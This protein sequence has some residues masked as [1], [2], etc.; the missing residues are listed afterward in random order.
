MPHVYVCVCVHVRV[1]VSV[2]ARVYACLSLCVSVCPCLSAR[3]S[4][5]GNAVHASCEHHVDF[6]VVYNIHGQL[7]Y[8]Q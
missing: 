7:G 5:C 6:L 4:V 3:V 1:H 2:C 8:K